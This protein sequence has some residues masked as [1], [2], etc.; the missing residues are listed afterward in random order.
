MRFSSVTMG[1]ILLGSACVGFCWA[2]WQARNEKIVAN[3][4]L[5]AMLR[6]RASGHIQARCEKCGSRCS[7]LSREIKLQKRKA[8]LVCD[9]C[10]R[11]MDAHALS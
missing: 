10:A 8:F 3:E 9:E 2:Q 7:A 4:L 1:L 11:R 5:A 6:K